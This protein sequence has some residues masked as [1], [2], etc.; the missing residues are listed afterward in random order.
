MRTASLLCIVFLHACPAPT[1]PPGPVVLPAEELAVEIESDIL[2]LEGNLALPA[3]TEGQGVPAIVLVHGSGPQSRDEVLGAQLNM[4]FGFDIPVFAQISESLAEGGIAV[5]R[6]DK[7]SCTSFNNTC[8]NDYPVPEGDIKTSDFTTDAIVAT[9]W[10]ADQEGIDP[11]RIFVVG[12]S[13]GGA[14]M[15]AILA[16][17]ANL[18][19]GVSLAGNFRPIDTLLRFQLDSSRTLLESL[20][21]TEAAIDDLLGDL[22]AMVEALEALRAGSFVGNYIGGLPVA[23]WEDAFAIGDARPGLI[24][25]ESR[26]MLAINGDTDTNIPH[27]PELVLWGQAGV[28]TLLFPCVTHALNCVGT[29]IGSE[30]EPALLSALSEWLLR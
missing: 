8:D 6:Y 29:E 20:G 10:L 19:G 13:Q 4:A 23:F 15:P 30:V 16:G 17:N 22:T 24:A 3:R 14:L 27:D 1:T 26:P 25:Q 28:D 11:E 21:Y 2:T 18:A 5:L 7:R 12:H 9:R